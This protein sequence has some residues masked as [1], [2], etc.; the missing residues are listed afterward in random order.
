M[1]VRGL[2]SPREPR[3]T[4]PTS[5]APAHAGMRQER[6][7]RDREDRAKVVAPG[8]LLP[9]SV[10]ASRS[11]GDRR[12]PDRWAGTGPRLPATSYGAMTATP[13]L[14]ATRIA[15]SDRDVPGDG[16]AHGQYGRCDRPLLGEDATY[17]PSRCLAGMGQ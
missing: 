14:C 4:T 11:L 6:R 12:E 10:G 17:S 5:E 3:A 1:I 16:R 7:V 8:E 13:I 2:V 15:Q 9:V